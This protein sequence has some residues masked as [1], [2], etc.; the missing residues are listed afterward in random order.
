MPKVVLYNLDE[1]LMKQRSIFG[2]INRPLF[3]PK[4]T[5]ITFLEKEMPKVVLYNLDGTLMK[6]RSFSG[7]INRPLFFPKQTK[8]TFAEHLRKNDHIIVFSD[9]TPDSE[10]KNALEA[11]GINI[12]KIKIIGGESAKNEEGVST[13]EKKV[14]IVEKEMRSGDFLSGVIVDNSLR[15]VSY[16]PQV[17][18]ILVPIT[19]TEAVPLWDHYLQ[20]PLLPA[21]VLQ[22]EIKPEVDKIKQST[23]NVL[24]LSDCNFLSNQLYHR[25]TSLYLFKVPASYEK[26]ANSQSGYEIGISILSDYCKNQGTCSPILGKLQ[27]FFSGHWN[28][29]HTDVVQELLNKASSKVTNEGGVITTTSETAESLL[30]ELEEKLLTAGNPLNPSG[31][32]ARRILF[33]QTKLELNVIDIPSLNAQIKERAR[34]NFRN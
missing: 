17:I 8:I 31:S 14:N 22:K 11:A 18:H 32:L 28:R 13:N 1:F 24:K 6:Q 34:N 21:I 15:V 25:F 27:R 10:I 2:E 7:E 4:Q 29:H 20:V 16:L 33:L 12:E 19:D 5:K 23:T 26:L 9:V 3:F 30:K